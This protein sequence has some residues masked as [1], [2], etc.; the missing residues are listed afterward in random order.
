MKCGFSGSLDSHTT[1]TPSRAQA[2]HALGAVYFPPQ[3][4]AYIRVTP[5]TVPISCRKNKN[6]CLGEGRPKLPV[7]G[8]KYF[9]PAR[10]PQ[11]SLLIAHEGIWS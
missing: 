7:Q 1:E 5:S 10:N 11:T 6:T 2:R 9:S 3:A 8:K 4:H